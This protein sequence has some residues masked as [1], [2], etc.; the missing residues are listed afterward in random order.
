MQQ[1]DYTITLDLDIGLYTAETPLIPDSYVI[2]DTPSHTFYNLGYIIENFILAQMDADKTPIDSYMVF[3]K[4]KTEIA[5]RGLADYLYYAADFTIADPSSQELQDLQ[6]SNNVAHALGLNPVE[7]Y[8]KSDEHQKTKMMIRTVSPKQ[9]LLFLEK[10][11]KQL[12]SKMQWYPITK[13]TYYAPKRWIWWYRSPY[14]EGLYLGE[15]KIIGDEIQY[16]TL[17]DD[18]RTAWNT[19]LPTENFHQAFARI[20]KY[21]IPLEKLHL[22]EATEIILREAAIMTVGDC[23]DFVERD[24]SVPMG[25]S[26]VGRFT[27]DMFD[28]IEHKLQENG[29]W[30]PDSKDDKL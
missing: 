15:T 16:F 5:E 23:I 22:R 8:L 9:F 14:Q 6:V 28:E 12:A 29:Y 2:G 13:A 25:H 1:I 17:Q 7:K 18:A 20:R 11:G 19:K 24:K 4:G 10:L 26:F 21:D 27:E 30:S 3:Q